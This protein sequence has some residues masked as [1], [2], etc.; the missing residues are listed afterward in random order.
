MDIDNKDSLNFSV[1]VDANSYDFRK[2]TRVYIPF[3]GSYY[4]GKGTGLLN[5]QGKVIIP[6]EYNLILGNF[7]EEG[8]LFRVA[9]ISSCSYENS[10]KYIGYRYLWGVYNSLGQKIIPLIYHDIYTN[11]NQSV[12]ITIKNN[13]YTVFNGAGKVIVQPGMYSEIYQYNYKGKYARV[14]KLIENNV[15]KYGVIDEKGQEV[16]RAI[17]DKIW[18]FRPE[19]YDYMMVEKYDKE[20]AQVK[21]YKIPFDNLDDIIPYTGSPR[22]PFSAMEERGE[23]G[24][25]MSFN[26]DK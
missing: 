22:P 5:K 11:E 7:Y 25:L 4:K 1:L 15:E 18:P 17:Y 20:M 6:P 24:E 2:D 9:K 16:I 10:D 3:R 21:R 23:L 19:H 12:F 14:K 8:S 13:T 26:F